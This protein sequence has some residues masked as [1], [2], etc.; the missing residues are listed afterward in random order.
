MFG[1]KAFGETKHLGWSD[2]VNHL[3]AFRYYLGMFSTTQG[4]VFHGCF[5]RFIDGKISDFRCKREALGCLFNRKDLK[6]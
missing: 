1:G 2:L 4:N 6:L 5:Q 3:K